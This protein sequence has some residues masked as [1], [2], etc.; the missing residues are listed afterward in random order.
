MLVS[1]LNVSRHTAGNANGNKPSITS[2][3]A[4]A[5]SQ[6][7]DV[8]NLLGLARTLQILEELRIGIEQQYIVLVF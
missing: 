8:P 5:V 4:K 3:S 7:S 6:V 1:F 2:M